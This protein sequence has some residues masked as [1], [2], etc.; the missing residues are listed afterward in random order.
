MI[1]EGLISLEVC[2]QLQFKSKYRHIELVI[3]NSVMYYGM[4]MPNELNIHI[5]TEKNYGRHKSCGDI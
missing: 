5:S 2:K 1:K 3:T 4:H